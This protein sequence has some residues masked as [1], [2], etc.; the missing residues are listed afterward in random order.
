LVSLIKSEKIS[1][2]AKSYLCLFHPFVFITQFVTFAVVVVIRHFFFYWVQETVF[3]AVSGWMYESCNHYTG[4][5]L[6]LELLGV[7]ST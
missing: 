4:I 6:V 2:N 3:W 5:P 1:A 7:V